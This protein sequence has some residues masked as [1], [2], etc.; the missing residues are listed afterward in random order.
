MSKRLRVLID[1]AELREIQRVARAKRMTVSE[2]VRQAL[3]AARQGELLQD[4]EKKM[5][6]VR[7]ASRHEFP[8]GDIQEILGEIKRGHLDGDST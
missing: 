3:R 4:I 1:E 6:I 5:A 2:W 7:V 8:T